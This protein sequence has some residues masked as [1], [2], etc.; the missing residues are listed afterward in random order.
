MIAMNPTNYILT[1][2]KNNFNIA[3]VSRIEK[4]GI[5]MEI[6]KS[7]NGIK[8]EPKTAW[9]TPK[10]IE[11]KDVSSTENNGINGADGGGT[12]FSSNTPS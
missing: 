1:M 7:W 11:L 4:V 5:P 10:I 3:Q 9:E 6:E 8:I 12:N 2:I